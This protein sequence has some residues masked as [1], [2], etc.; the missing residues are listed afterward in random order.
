MMI[1]ALIG[2]SGCDALNKAQDTLDGL[3]D[4]V[5]VEGI[6]LGVEAPDNA[7]L[8]GLLAGSDFEAG[9]SATVFMAD[10]KEVQEIENAPISGADVTLNEVA[11]PEVEP[12]IYLMPPAGAA[13]PYASGD[14]WDLRIVR[15]SGDS[16]GTSIAAVFLPEPA[17]FSVEIPQQ[18]ANNTAI[19]LDFTGLGFD[20]VLIVVI[21]DG[22]NVTYSNEPSGIKELYDFTH[23]TAELGVI[24]IPPE[25]FP[26]D[27]LYAVGVAGMV[28]TDA[29]DLEEMNTGLSA[30]LSGMMRMYPVSTIP[31]PIP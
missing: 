30:I 17:D 2:L 22:G 9:T 6:V 7:Q 13:L 31:L 4:P 10:A 1:L 25:A 12:G 5:V 18:H 8:D 16:T 3:L 14:T 27:G 26:A 21:D 29:V 20:A 28:N 11:V 23:G 24:T 19:P 15:T